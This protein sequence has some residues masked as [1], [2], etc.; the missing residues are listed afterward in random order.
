[1][2]LRLPPSIR[3]RFTIVIVTVIVIVLAALM[4]S[5]L[6]DFS[7]PHPVFG[8]T[9]SDVYARDELGLDPKATFIAILDELQPKTLRL[10]A[11]WNQ[12]EATRGAYDFSSLDFQIGEAQKREIPV[13]LAIGYR[14]PRWPECHIPEWAGG[15]SLLDSHQAL[16]DYM[17]AVIAHYKTSKVL[18]V[19]QVENEPLLGVFGNCPPPDREFVKQEI[20]FVKSKDPTRPILTTASGELSLWTSTAGLSELFGTTLYRYVW[21]K[22]TGP[23]T[24]IYPPAFYALR[25]WYA[26]QFLGVQDVSIIELQAEPWGEGKPLPQTSFDDQIKNFG[27][28][29]LKSI[30]SFA[31]RTGIREVYLWG[32]EWWYYRKLH[33]DSSFWNAGKEIFADVRDKD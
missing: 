32:P 11:Y 31:R 3:R 33:G 26:K 4:A 20:A 2:I 5:W 23:F 6:L 27:V 9:F 25:A 19:W 29:E 21:N 10:V 8:L 16:F 15:L 28:P 24:H 18:S 17:S 13:V 22:Y 12:V 14:T 1:M 7:D 30:V